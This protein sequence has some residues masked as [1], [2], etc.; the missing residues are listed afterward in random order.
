ME[1]EAVEVE[2]GLD[3]LLEGDLVLAPGPVE[4]PRPA[5]A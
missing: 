2:G 5:I 4:V 3:T 1:D